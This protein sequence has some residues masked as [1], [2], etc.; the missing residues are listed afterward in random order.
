M[1]W[2]IFIWYEKGLPHI[3]KPEIGTMKNTAT[4]EVEAVNLILEIPKKA[5]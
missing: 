4:K 2:G 3:W 5:E 1:F